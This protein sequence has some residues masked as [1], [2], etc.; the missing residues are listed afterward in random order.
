MI[1]IVFAIVD[2]QYFLALLDLM[3]T[4]NSFDDLK[5]NAFFS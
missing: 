1:G 2:I 5:K 4:V 3:T